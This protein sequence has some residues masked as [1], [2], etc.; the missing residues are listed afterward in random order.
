MSRPMAYPQSVI[1]MVPLSLSHHGFPT[2][3]TVASWSSSPCRASPHAIGRWPR[4]PVSR[5]RRSAHGA[6]PCAAP[7]LPAGNRAAGRWGRRQGH[8]GAHRIALGTDGTLEKA[9]RPPKLAHLNPHALRQ[10]VRDALHPGGRF[11]RIDERGKGGRLP[12]ALRRAE[13][14]VSHVNRGELG[15]ALRLG[16]TAMPRQRHGADHSQPYA[17]SHVCILSSR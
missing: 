17:S 2:G 13:R 5:S 12:Q 7:A 14:V 4:P 15:G 11:G 3:S 10:Q 16:L 1:G 9:P 6:V 8:G